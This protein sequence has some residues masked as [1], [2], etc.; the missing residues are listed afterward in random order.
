MARAISGCA[1]YAAG[2]GV[3]PSPVAPDVPDVPDVRVV[4]DEQAAAAGLTGVELVDTFLEDETDGTRMLTHWFKHAAERTSRVGD[5]AVYI[6][7]DRESDAVEC[8]TAIFPEQTVEP[9]YVPPSPILT[10]VY[11]P[12]T[13]MVTHY[14]QRCRLVPHQEWQTQTTY[15]SQYD[16]FS[17]STR[18]VPQTR[19]VSRTTMRNEC[20]QEAVSRME[21]QWQW[22]PQTRYSPPRVEYLSVNRLR[23]SEPVCYAVEKGAVTRVVGTVFTAGAAR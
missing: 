12:V 16:F 3:H 14:E 20:H 17:K 10:G 21:T 13:R 6:V 4:T 8:R 5:V 2:A 9:H 22:G 18:M 1:L 15:S 11:S 19:Q 7:R 23:Q